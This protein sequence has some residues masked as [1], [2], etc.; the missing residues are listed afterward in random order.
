MKP[1][2]VM[3][4][5]VWQENMLGENQLRF[6]AEP[7]AFNADGQC[8]SAGFNAEEAGL[9]RDLEGFKVE[10]WRAPRDDKF[11]CWRPEF[12]D[13]HSV[14]LA[15]AETM[16]KVLRRVNKQ[17]NALVERFGFPSGPAQWTAYAAEALGIRGERPFVRYS[18]E[19]RPDGT[20]FH[21]MSADWLAGWLARE[22][23]D[24]AEKHGVVE[25]RAPS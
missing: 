20:H 4:V 1:Y 23:R 24:Y 6:T 3:L 9:S 15:R 25:M 13:I 17:L 7:A 2:K 18:K 22:E 19:M 21:H 5:R 12:R 14:D 8:Y 11:N 16:V 10:A